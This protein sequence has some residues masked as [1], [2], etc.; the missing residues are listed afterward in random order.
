MPGTKYTLT[1]FDN[2]Y[3]KYIVDTLPD[4]LRASGAKEGSKSGIEIAYEFTSAFFYLNHVT[5]QTAGFARDLTEI[6]HNMLSDYVTNAAIAI[7]SVAMRQSITIRHIVEHFTQAQ[8]HIIRK[9]KSKLL[10][11]C[12]MIEDRAI[13][14][15]NT[16]SENVKVAQEEE[17]I[18]RLMAAEKV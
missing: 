3:L 9:D 14:I 15:V 7:S 6:D 17:M 8:T 10:R 11:I 4:M 18:T 2:G 1:R 12:G 13:A 5:A 16:I